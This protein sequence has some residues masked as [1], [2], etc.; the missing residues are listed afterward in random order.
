MRDERYGT[1]EAI[2]LLDFPA[3]E[4]ETSAFEARCEAPASQWQ[5]P[6]AARR[7]RG[8][9]VWRLVGR[10]D[11]SKTRKAWRG[12]RTVPG[13]VRCPDRSTSPPPFSAVDVCGSVS[14]KR[15]RPGEA[16]ARPPGPVRR[17][18]EVQSGTSNTHRRI[19]QA[20]TDRHGAPIRR[21]DE[22]TASS[23]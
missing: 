18:F 11:A 10:R 4:S 1:R 17:R 12:A 9:A 3:H 5:R 8:P 16:R 21:G 15:E 13:S 19:P 7:R 20:S 14:L 6:K 22:R 2:E 23:T